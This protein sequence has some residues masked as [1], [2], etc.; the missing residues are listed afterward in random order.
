MKRLIVVTMAC[1]ASASVAQSDPG[2]DASDPSA[3]VPPVG[4]RSA[5]AGYRPYAEQEHLSWREANEEMRRL[6]GHR[7]H[8]PKPPRKAQDKKEQRR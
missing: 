2:Q 8:V 3:R 4:H 6:G 5:F 7:G 1:F